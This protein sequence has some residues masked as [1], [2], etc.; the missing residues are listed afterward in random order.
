VIIVGTHLDWIEPH[1]RE[2]CTRKYEEIIR[3][4]FTNEHCEAL[5]NYWP[6]IASIHFVGLL[7]GKGL[8]LNVKE[9]REDIYTTALNLKVPYG[10]F[11]LCLE[12]VYGNSMYCNTLT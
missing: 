3:R 11:V 2:A 12:K 6:N 5:P 7:Q 4:Y 10:K 8:D 9:L 1:E